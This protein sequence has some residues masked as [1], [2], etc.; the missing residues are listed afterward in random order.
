MRQMH[1]V[2]EDPA[3]VFVA[4]CCICVY[5]ICCVNTETGRALGNTINRAERG[6]EGA[7]LDFQLS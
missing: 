7:E 3:A 2:I 6:R 1:A 5:C 4:V